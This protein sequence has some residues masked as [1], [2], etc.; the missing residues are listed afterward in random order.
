MAIAGDRAGTGTN[1]LV[2]SPVGRIP[3]LYGIGS[4]AAHRRAAASA[5]ATLEIVRRAGLSFDIDTP[6][7]FE[8]ME[9]IMRETLPIGAGASRFR[10]IGM[11]RA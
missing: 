1:A 5:G 10:P 3:Y 2:I 11:V 4:F 9:D 6:D 8:Q 7:D